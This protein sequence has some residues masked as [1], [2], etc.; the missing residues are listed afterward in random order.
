MG[1]YF[2]TQ[3]STFRSRD[4]ISKGLPSTHDYTHWFNRPFCSET[5]FLRRTVQMLRN[6][7][8]ARFRLFLHLSS[9]SLLE[10]MILRYSWFSIQ[11]WPCQSQFFFRSWRTC[12]KQKI[13]SA[14][15]VCVSTR[16]L[17]RERRVVASVVL[18]DSSTRPRFT[19]AKVLVLPKYN[20]WPF[21]LLH[22]MSSGACKHV[23]LDVSRR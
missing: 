14:I 10:W 9:S 23:G 21:N 12:W 1:R 8:H 11:A 7:N 19:H 22:S 3:F 13:F 2:P 5:P 18:G 20:A 4:N 6:S 15:S 16:H 17:P